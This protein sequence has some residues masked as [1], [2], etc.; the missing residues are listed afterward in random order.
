MISKSPQVNSG[1]LLISLCLGLS[2]CGIFGYDSG[3]D[4]AKIIP[5]PPEKVGTSN[6][7]T[8]PQPTKTDASGSKKQTKKISAT[9]PPTTTRIQERRANGVV[10]EIKVKNRGN[11]PDY[12]IYPEAPQPTNDNM[13][14]KVS[15]PTWQINW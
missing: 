1:V 11:I 4:G 6:T 10:T 8:V 2:G 14:N 3:S 9:V 7:I 13:P 12:Y 5:V 15:P